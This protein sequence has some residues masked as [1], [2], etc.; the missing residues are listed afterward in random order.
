MAIENL[1][2]H[3]ILSLFNFYSL[4]L[5]I[6]KAGQNRSDLPSP[7]PSSFASPHVWLCFLIDLSSRS[8]FSLMLLELAR[9]GYWIWAA[10]ISFVWRFCSST[11]GI[12]GFLW[13]L[14]RLK[15]KQHLDVKAKK[16][17]LL[18]CVVVTLRHQSREEEEEKEEYHGRC[19]SGQQI[20][21]YFG[22]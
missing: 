5:A 7:V 19:R 21:F 17:I 20:F 15:T 6:Y 14:K 9:L 18:H 11:V 10:T 16:L 8:F 13:I 2:N 3:M 22:S 12:A 4:F 1:N